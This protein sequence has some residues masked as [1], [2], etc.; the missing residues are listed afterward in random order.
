MMAD[1]SPLLAE[2]VQAGIR[3]SVADGKLVVEAPAGVVKPELLARLKQHKAALLAALSARPAAPVAEPKL[4]DSPAAATPAAPSAPVEAVEAVEPLAVAEQPIPLAEPTPAVAEP[5]APVAAAPVEP[6]TLPPGW[7]ADIPAPAW[8][9]EFCSILGGIRLLASRRQQCGDPGCGF[10]VAVEWEA[11]GYPRQWACPKCGLAAAPVADPPAAR[12]VEH[13]EAPQPAVDVIEWRYP[14]TPRPGFR[15]KP[16]ACG[17]HGRDTE[18]WQ[19]DNR[20]RCVRCNPP[21]RQ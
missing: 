15:N 21:A 20:W 2:C 19:D 3:L 7:P 12:P 8:W 9:P 14:L 18:W 13:P 6:T 11:P 4:L 10:P 1:F 16:R 5:T 17:W